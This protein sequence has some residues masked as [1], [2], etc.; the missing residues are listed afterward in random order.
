MEE[1]CLV[2]MSGLVCSAV[3]KNRFRSRHSLLLLCKTVA[4]VWIL[5]VSVMNAFCF[6]IKEIEKVRFTF[7]GCVCLCICSV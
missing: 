2:L 3:L 5:N 6:Q 7:I 4:L 1:R